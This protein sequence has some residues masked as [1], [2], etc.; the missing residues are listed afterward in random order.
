MFALFRLDKEQLS[1]CL[2]RW[3]SKPDLPMWEA[4]R[5][6]ILAEV[7]TLA[8]AEQIAEAALAKVRSRLQPFRLDYQALSQEAGSCLS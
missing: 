7:G 1:S 6:A 5:A 8:E 2:Q 3:P 4:R